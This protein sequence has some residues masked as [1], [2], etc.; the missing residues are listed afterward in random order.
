MAALEA[1]L[2]KPYLQALPEKINGLLQEPA[3]IETYTEIRAGK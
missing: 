2:K 3:R 1:H